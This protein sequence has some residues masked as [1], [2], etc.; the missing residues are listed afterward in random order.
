[1]SYVRIYSFTRLPLPIQKELSTYKSAINEDSEYEDDET[2]LKKYK[3][4]Y[5][6]N[7]IRVIDD[8][9]AYI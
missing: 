8:P 9:V 1:M 7:L 4:N 5:L 3:G 2:V 6:D